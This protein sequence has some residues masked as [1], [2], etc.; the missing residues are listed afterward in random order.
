MSVNGVGYYGNYYGVNNI[1]SLY[2]HQIQNASQKV[3]RVS[4]SSYSN[5]RRYVEKSSAGF[6]KSYNSSM[7]SLMTSANALKSTNKSSVWNKLSASSSDTKIIEVKQ[8]YSMN[9]KDTYDVSVKQLAQTQKNIS[10]QV[11]KNSYASSDAAVSISNAY[12]DF[13]FQVSHKDENGRLK[14]NGQILDEIA[15]V[16]NQSGIGIQAEVLTKDGQA[17]L[18]LVSKET[19]EENAFRVT[20]DFAE[21][22]GLTNISRLAQ[23]AVYTVSKNGHEGKEYTASSNTVSIDYGRVDAT[24]KSE[25][26]STI[27]VGVN[28]DQVVSAVKDLVKNY[29]STVQ[30]LGRNADRGYGVEKQLNNM[31]NLP[32]SEKSLA[33]TGITRNKDGLLELD[34]EKLR[35]SLEE[36]PS[37]VKEVI[38]GSF[39]LSQTLFEDGRKGLSQSGASL[40]ENDLGIAEQRETADLFSL[41][42]RYSRSGAY[43]VSNFYTVGNLINMLV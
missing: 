19:G 43:A 34:E 39:S 4:D 28:K 2:R 35:S 30:M 24:L 40:I 20:G 11:D 9:S 17:Q 8:N 3:S 23:D 25:G 42:N 6:L 13:T 18:S 29:N 38:G 7:A 12:G 5:L 22:S 33:L 21:K 26:N 10:Q 36:N 27:G 32:L 31:L 14:T 16:V 1:S 37:L 15:S 41:L